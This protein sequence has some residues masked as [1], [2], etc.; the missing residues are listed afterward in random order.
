MTHPWPGAIAVTGELDIVTAPRLRAALADPEVEE[1]DLTEV[2][3]MGVAG[4]QVLL[5]ANA[6]RGRPLVLVGP[7]DRVLRLLD[8]CGGRDLFEIRGP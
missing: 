1:V 7:S 5:A 6:D 8:L 3:F 2:S 4:V